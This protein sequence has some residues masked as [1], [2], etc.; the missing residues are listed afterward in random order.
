MRLTRHTGQGRLAYVR[1]HACAMY[2]YCPSCGDE[3]H[4]VKVDYHYGPFTGAGLAYWQYCVECTFMGGVT[5]F[6]ARIEES[7]A[8]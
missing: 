6:K 7:E 1:T 8:R 3:L 5:L 4:R 2:S